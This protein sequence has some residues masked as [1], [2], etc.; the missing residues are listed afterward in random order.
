MIANVVVF[1]LWRIHGYQ[2]EATGARSIG[3]SSKG[4]LFGYET[5][6]RR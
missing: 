6:V 4:A 1:P 5:R 2:I 3:H